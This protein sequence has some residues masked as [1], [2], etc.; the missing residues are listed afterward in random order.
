VVLADVFDIDDEE[1]IGLCDFI[2]EALFLIADLDLDGDT[3]TFEGIS[4]G[5]RFQGAPVSVSGMLLP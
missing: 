5:I 4:A 1:A 3:E 2:P